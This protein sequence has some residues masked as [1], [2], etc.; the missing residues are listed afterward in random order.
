MSAPSRARAQ[1]SDSD[2]DDLMP[3]DTDDFMLCAAADSM[4]P[5]PSGHRAL[6]P[7]QSPR[8]LQPTPYA[9]RNV[10]R[11]RSL[12]SRIHALQGPLGLLSNSTFKLGFYR[13]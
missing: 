3:G 13:A 8:R 7:I 1:G 12:P 2:T 9:C 6:V 4:R 11:T 10:S 5:V